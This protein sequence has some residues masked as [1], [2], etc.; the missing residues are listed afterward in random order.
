MISSPDDLLTISPGNSL[1]NSDMIILG[2][3]T[4]QAKFSTP[5]LGEAQAA[6]VRA[7]ASAGLDMQ[8]VI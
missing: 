7:A 2:Y 4:A 1:R 6:H 8:I 5:K 3:T